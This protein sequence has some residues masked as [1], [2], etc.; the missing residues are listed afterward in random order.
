[1]TTPL[2]L[3]AAPGEQLDATLAGRRGAGAVGDLARPPLGDDA[4]DLVRAVVGAPTDELALI[5]TKF[6]PGRSLTAYYVAR[7]TGGDP[8]PLAITWTARP[9]SGRV[10]PSATS[11]DGR[12]MIVAAPDDSL[13]PGLRRLTDPSELAGALAGL[14]PELA[15]PGAAVAV[16]TVR[17]RPG[18]RHVLR[19]DLATTPSRRVF[20][21]V[22]RDDSGARAVQV[23]AAWRDRLDAARHHVGVVEPVG[24]LPVEHAAVWRESP[25][26]TLSEVLRRRSPPAALLWRVGAALRALHDAGLGLA[27]ASWPGHDAAAELRATVRAG[28]IVDGLAPALGHRYRAVASE[29]LDRLP[30]TPADAITATHGDVKGDNLVVDHGRVVFLDL[31]R[32]ARGDRALDLGKLLADLRWSDS[33]GSE[34]SRTAA[35]VEGYGHTDPTCW[36]RARMLSVLFHVKL[37]ARRTAVHAPNWDGHMSAAVAVAEALLREERA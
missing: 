21:K 16:H 12:T 36:R 34:R 20:V 29:V 37:A 28:E 25:G 18:Q 22:D 8:R 35:L 13:L 10:T 33:G 24:Y 15:A 32:T 27:D 5:R 26:P 17:Y 14:S 9:F 31:D 2:E 23:A 6:K 3:A 4:A 1:M 30:A 7:S 11:A 19:V